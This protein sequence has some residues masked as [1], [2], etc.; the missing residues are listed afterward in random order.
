M[1]AGVATLAGDKIDYK[2]KFVTRH[3]EKHFIMMKVSIHQGNKQ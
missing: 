2:T 1:R 3:K